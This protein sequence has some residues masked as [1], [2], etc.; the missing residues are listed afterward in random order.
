M[1][2]RRDYVRSCSSRAIRD[3]VSMKV[4]AVVYFNAVNPERAIM[5]VQSYLPATTMLAQTTLRAVNSAPHSA[6]YPNSSAGGG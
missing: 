2:R 6:G 1:E 5:Q 3:N 4:D